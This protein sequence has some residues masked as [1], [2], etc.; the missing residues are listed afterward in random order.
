MTLTEVADFLRNKTMPN[1]LR[2]LFNKMKRIFNFTIERNNRV[3]RFKKILEEYDAGIPLKKI[4]ENYGCSRSTVL[5]YARIAGR[6]RRPKSD[7]PQRRAMIIGHK[8]KLPQSEI[9]RL[10]GCSIGLVSMVEHEAGLK[11]YKGSGK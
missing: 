2:I 7:D 10:C 8:A 1:G 6:P 3:V 4:V 5:R 9:A 11:R